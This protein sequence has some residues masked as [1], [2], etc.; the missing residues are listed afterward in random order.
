VPS[1][2][3]TKIYATDYYSI[4]QRNRP[5]KSD[6]KIQQPVG[7]FCKNEQFR[8]DMPRGISGTHEEAY[9]FASRL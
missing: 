2:I 1:H 9:S 8:R 6:G 3:S 5:E 4:I 7:R